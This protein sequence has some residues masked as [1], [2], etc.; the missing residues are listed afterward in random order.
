[1]GTIIKK[2]CKLSPEIAL[3]MPSKSFVKIKRNNGIL[4]ISIII[5]TFSN[6]WSKV[7]LLGLNVHVIYSLGDTFSYPCMNWY[8]EGLCIKGFHL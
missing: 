4:K 7:L 6:P 3:P 1:M 5:K 2:L 8:M